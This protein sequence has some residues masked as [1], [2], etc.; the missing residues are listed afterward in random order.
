[1]TFRLAVIRTSDE[2]GDEALVAAL[3]GR[4]DVDVVLC[5]PG[6]VKPL[7]RRLEAEGVAAVLATGADRELLAAAAAAAR[8][9]GRPAILRTDWNDL[10]EH[11]LLDRWRRRRTVRRFRIVLTVGTANRRF[12]ESCGIGPGRLGTAPIGVDTDELLRAARDLRPRR[13]ELREQLGIAPDWF[14]A[15]FVDPLEEAYRPFDV[16]DALATGRRENSSLRILVLGEGSLEAELRRRV[17]DQRLPVSFAERRDGTG[18]LTAFSAADAVV[19]PGDARVRRSRGVHEAMVSGLAAVVSLAVGFR[20]DLIEDGVTGF[21]HAVGDAAAL[22]GCLATLGA[23]P[24]RAAV[25]GD[26]A[27]LRASAFSVERAVDGIV[28]SLRRL[29]PAPDAGRR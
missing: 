26:A 28:E 5:E 8:R 13:R 4:E 29:V 3:S 11:G 14:C 22:V 21:T 12:V 23:D 16:L 9:S 7:A 2:A 10:E 24:I 18:R 19:C 17:R 25:M 27:R 6:D 15:L 20:E 1:M